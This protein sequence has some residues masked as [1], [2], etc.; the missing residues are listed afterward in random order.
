MIPKRNSLG[1][2]RISDTSKDARNT[3][4]ISVLYLDD[5]PELVNLI[6][7]YLERTGDMMVD[8]SVSFEEAMNKMRYISYDVIVTDYNAKG[9]NGNELL[10][11]VRAKG[12]RIPFV[13]FV[14]FSDSQHENE[15]KQ[16]KQVSFIEKM[17]NSGANFS[18]L[19]Q[20]IL[21]SVSENRINTVMRRGQSVVS[22]DGSAKS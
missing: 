8:T 16:L 11:N 5:D 22:P 7:M 20:E 10:R 12:E 1:R 3:R 13:Y 4:L 2:F 18:K 17:G 14:V 15:A 6:C 9:N 19:R 21:E